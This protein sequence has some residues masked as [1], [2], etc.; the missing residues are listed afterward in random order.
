ML[1]SDHLII[2]SGLEG[3]HAVN[4]ATF[5]IVEKQTICVKTHETCL[6]PLERPLTKSVL[7]LVQLV[8]PAGS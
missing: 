5:S 7:L 2:A 4:C 8:V 1:L 6:G 3:L